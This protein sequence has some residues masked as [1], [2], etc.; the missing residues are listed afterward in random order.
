MYGFLVKHDVVLYAPCL[1]GLLSTSGQIGVNFWY[2]NG[3]TKDV[4]E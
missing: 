2:G 3:T 4:K 1:I